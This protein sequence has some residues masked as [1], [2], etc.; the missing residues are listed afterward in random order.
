MDTQN[1]THMA[2]RIGQFFESF[3]D[4][5]EALDGIATHIHKFWDPRMRRLLLQQLDA[6]SDPGT[7]PAL[8]PLV[9]DALRAHRQRLT[10]SEFSN[11]T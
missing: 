4:R 1:L 5:T 2:N 6:A 3:S 9:A 11:F 7:P 10:P 8:S